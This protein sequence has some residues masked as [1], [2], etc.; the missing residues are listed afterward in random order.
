MP[1][2]KGSI[3]ALVTPFKSTGEI[4]YEKYRS[5]LEWHITEGSNGLCVLGTTSE[6]AVMTNEERVKMLAITQQVA[7]GR[8]PY[9]VGIGAINPAV[10]IS[11]AKQALEYGA[12]ASLIVTPYHV[13]PTQKGL[14][15]HYKMIASAVPELPIIMYNVPG[16][17]GVDM[18]PETAAEVAKACNGV[19]IGYKEASGDVSRVPTLRSLC[20]PDLLLY[21]GD[22]ST[23]AEFT[24]LGGDGCISVTANVLPSQV[25][26]VMASALTK[27]EVKTR[28]LDKRLAVMHDGCGAQSNPIPV[29]HVLNRMG[30]IDKYL[31][32][33]LLELELEFESILD[34]AMRETGLL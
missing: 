13:K 17:T 29:K 12:D 16:R 20:G 26:K 23:A 32:P 9:M 7:K 25:S 21:S 18:S 15:H 6:A 30:R 2:N 22:D 5:L 3:V 28:A 11:N 1:L 4:D 27:D 24:L 33:P 34:A 8:I 10:C 14:V 19:V 31:R